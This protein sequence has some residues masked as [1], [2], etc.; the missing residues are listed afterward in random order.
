MR[1]IPIA[2]LAALVL[3]AGCNDDPP[4]PVTAPPHRDV[5][6]PPDEPPPRLLFYAD[7]AARPQL[8]PALSHPGVAAAAGAAP[9][10]EPD[11]GRAFAL[12]ANVRGRDVQITFLPMP[13]RS[14][15]DE[16]M[17]VAHVR[18]GNDE[19]VQAAMVRRSPPSAGTFSRHG[20]LWIA[21]ADAP[22]LPGAARW[23]DDQKADFWNCV[24]DRS[25]TNVVAC[26]I[27]CVFTTGGWLPCV[28]GCTTVGEITIIAGCAARVL[29]NAWMGRYQ[30]KESER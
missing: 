20:T 9:D 23:S 27:G 21:A 14:D 26:A 5:R 24:I 8:E 19:A 4:R 18:C 29:V 6:T 30:P 3:F 15:P 13:A 11:V 10:Y 2:A 16:L 12:A 22:A 7:D 25:T 17:L 1:S 28:A